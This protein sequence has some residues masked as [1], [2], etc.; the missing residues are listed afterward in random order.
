MVV[1]LAEL[2][3]EAGNYV[4]TAGQVQAADE[5]MASSQGRVAEAVGQ[6]ERRLQD[7][8]RQLEY[9]RR[10]IDDGYAAQRNFERGQLTLNRALEQGRITAAEH[11]RYL[12]LLRERYQ[13]TGAAAA[14]AAGGGRNFGSVMGQAGYQVQDFATQ[15]SMGGNALTAF[16]V[17]GAQL[18]SL[19]GP[20]GII[21]GAALTVGAIAGNLLMAS[22]AAKEAKDSTVNYSE[23]MKLAKELTGEAAEA[24]ERLAK[25]QRAQAIE[26]RQAALASAEGAL[27]AA[28]ANLEQLR[29]I[30][31]LGR[32]DA[33]GPLDQTDT[34]TAVRAE[35]ERMT[36][37]LAKLQAA[38]DQAQVRLGTAVQGAGEFAPPSTRPIRNAAESTAQWDRVL[39]EGDSVRKSVLTD[40]ERYAETQARLGDLLAADAITLETYTRAL[41]AADPAI[42]AAADAQ[43]RLA[44]QGAS[45]ATS[46]Q[47]PEERARGAIGQAGALRGAGAIS[48]ETYE[49]A[50]ARANEELARTNPILREIERTSD[51]A[52]DTVGRAITEAFVQGEG[53]AIRFRNVAVGVLSE[54]AQAALRMAVI[55][56]LTRALTA[57]VGSAF[58]GGIA[59]GYDPVGTPSL[60]PNAF[61]GPRADGG[62]VDPS[63]WYVVGERGPEVFVP[64]TAGTIVPNGAGGGTVTI[65]NHFNSGVT[66]QEVFTLIPVIEARVKQ[67]VADGRQR[68]GSYARA[69]GA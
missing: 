4:A 51:R 6:T 19:F 13:A 3:L 67:A 48:Q 26:T 22:S 46:L 38:V 18:A 14:A 25:A 21:I 49:R 45:L 10:Q 36:T 20:Q 32:F 43:A 28:Q 12:E 34:N 9:L 5:R 47:T 44:S 65:H 8:G 16:A 27:A 54:I 33:A 60:N 7:G 56:P 17:Q 59:G 68:G 66:R 1:K 35:I 57:A 50:V 11:A 37:G 41:R 42:R 62:P 24:A 40:T 55:S 69:M 23:A 29:T 2:R 15:V 52:F 63:K 53:G 30:E 61:G 31:A 58:G 39:S 64:Q